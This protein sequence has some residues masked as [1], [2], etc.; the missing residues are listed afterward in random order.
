MDEQV[1]WSYR[2]W[3]TEKRVN[4]NFQ[5]VAEKGHYAGWIEGCSLGI[6]FGEDPKEIM[7]LYFFNIKG[8]KLEVSRGKGI[9]EELVVPD[10]FTQEEE[11]LPSKK[12]S[13]EKAPSI[14]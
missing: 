4:F 6:L 14:G 12:A 10:L 8:K 3:M 9:T 1:V 5:L 2:R 11:C 13:L 7:R